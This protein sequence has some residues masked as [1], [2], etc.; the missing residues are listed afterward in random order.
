MMTILTGSTIVFSR[1]CKSTDDEAVDPAPG[2]VAVFPAVG[3]KTQPFRTV[4]HGRRTF[5]GAQEVMLIL[6]SRFVVCCSK[7]HDLHC[8]CASA[9]RIR[10]A[11]QATLRSY[12]A[13]EIGAVHCPSEHGYNATFS[14]S[15]GTR[16]DG[17]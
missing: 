8:P 2:L 6:G 10:S 1:I 14:R 4:L 9:S 15:G 17:R 11:C 13:T 3:S 16:G 5:E 12:K 7:Q